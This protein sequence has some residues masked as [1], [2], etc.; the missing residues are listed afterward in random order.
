[1]HL[2]ETPLFAPLEGLEAGSTLVLDDAELAH[3]KV[4]RLNAGDTLDLVDGRGRS[5]R[6]RTLNAKRGELVLEEIL[7][8][9]RVRPAEPALAIG[10]LKGN[11][12]EEVLDHCAQMPLRALQPLWCDHG[13]RA[14]GA[15]AAEGLEKRLRAKARVALKQSRRLWATEI[16]PPKSLDEWLA[17][18]PGTIVLLDEEGERA[19]ELPGAASGLWLL[20]GPEGGFSARELG[21]VGPD[22]VKLSLGPTRLR[23]K[24][25]PIFALGALGALLARR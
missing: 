21:L 13:Q 23:A 7:A 19:P 12:L 8:D 1:M 10:A 11:A 18:A 6:A 14:K 16:L 5:A 4:F 17:G 24:S 2:D 3:L 9:E 22:A 20:C 25:A 15:D